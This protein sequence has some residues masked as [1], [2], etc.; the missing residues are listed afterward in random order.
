MTALIKEIDDHGFESE[1]LESNKPVL[2]DFWASWCGPCRAI[3]P[4]VETLAAEYGDHMKFAKINIDDNRLTLE[5]YGIKSIPTI[6][7]FKNGRPLEMI[8][9]LTTRDRLEKSIRDILEGAETAQPF[10]A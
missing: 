7:V 1:V 2:I 3:A 8:T 6:A 10:I 5:K 9:G 4:L